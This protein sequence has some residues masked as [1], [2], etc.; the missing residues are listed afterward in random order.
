VFDWLKSDPE[1]RRDVIAALGLDATANNASAASGGAPSKVTVNVD[2]LLS[3]E[4]PGATVTQFQTFDAQGTVFGWP[5]DV[6]A[7]IVK[8]GADLFIVPLSNDGS[9]GSV[10]RPDLA[11]VLRMATLYEQM[12]RFTLNQRVKFAVIGTELTESAQKVASTIQVRFL[13]P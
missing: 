6:S 11:L 1:F 9:Y 5:E 4:F 10:D 7:K 12:N 8:H 3:K 13:H 2:Q